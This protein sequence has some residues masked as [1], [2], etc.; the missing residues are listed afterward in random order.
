ME[1]VEKKIV[2]SNE[3]AQFQGVGQW[4]TYCAVLLDED[5][6]GVFEDFIVQL[7][8]ETRVVACVYL[9]RDIYDPNTGDLCI[10]FQVPDDFTPGTY[11]LYLYWHSQVDP[12]TLIT[13]PEGRSTGINY[14]IVEKRNVSVSN[15]KI[16]HPQ[17]PGQW[18]SYRAILLDEYGKT[19]PEKFYVQLYV[20]SD[21]AVH[22]PVS[23]F[24]G[25]TN[26]YTSRF[27]T[28]YKPIDR[29][30]TVT[31]YIDESEVSED[32]YTVNYEDGVIE[33][34][35]PPPKGEKC[36]GSS[37]TI[38]YTAFTSGD[39]PLGGA[40][41]SSDVYDSDGNLEFAFK[42]PE[43]FTEGTYSVWLSWGSQVIDEKK[44]LE[45]NG[46][47]LPLIVTTDVRQVIVENEWIEL[48]Q[49]HPGDKT[50]YHAVMHD[51]K[52]E[53]LP[54]EIATELLLDNTVVAKAFLSPDVY[55]PITK[56]VKLA[57]KVPEDV[58]PGTYTVKLKWHEYVTGGELP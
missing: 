13:Y 3:K 2:V 46:L 29:A 42:V 55:N 1:M 25:F 57:F 31:V 58:T 52:G 10:S 33:F 4:T 23:E 6:N 7:Y 50:S 32:K 54:P 39:L 53:A 49:V 44:Y 28:S 15:E 17:A 20:H 36:P 16:L 51:E 27:Y 21:E 12:N 19:L 5:G 47:K 48:P 9:H 8:L 45:G 14:K 34:L 26:G 30:S 11:P 24:I 43:D 56:E 41:M 35:E 18:T 40:Y 22:I 37:V 38:D